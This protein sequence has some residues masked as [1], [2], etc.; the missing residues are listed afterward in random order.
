MCITNEM[1]LSVLV[2]ATLDDRIGMLKKLTSNGSPEPSSPGKST[3]KVLSADGKTCETPLSFSKHQ[4]GTTSKIK[5]TSDTTCPSGG[6]CPPKS[7]AGKGLASLKGSTLKDTTG[8]W[9]TLRKPEGQTRY[10]SGTT[11]GTRSRL[12]LTLTPEGDFEPPESDPK[13]DKFKADL[14]DQLVNETP[15]ETMYRLKPENWP[16]TDWRRYL[17]IPMTMSWCPATDPRECLDKHERHERIVMSMLLGVETTFEYFRVVAAEQKKW[18]IKTMMAEAAAKRA[19]NAEINRMIRKQAGPCKNRIGDV[20]HEEWSHITMAFLT[21]IIDMIICL[22]QILSRAWKGVIQ[23]HLAAAVVYVTPKHPHVWIDNKI[24]GMRTKMRGVPLSLSNYDAIWMLLQISHKHIV[25]GFWP[26]FAEI[27][28]L[29]Q[30]YAARLTTQVY[31]V[32]ML[33][34]KYQYGT[35]AAVMLLKHCYYVVIHACFP[36]MR[37]FKP[38]RQHYDEYVDED[39][40]RGWHHTRVKVATQLYLR[41]ILGLV[42]W[43]AIGREKSLEWLARCLLKASNTCREA[44][45]A[46]RRESVDRSIQVPQTPRHSTIGGQLTPSGQHEITPGGTRRLLPDSI[47][48]NL[49]QSRKALSKCANAKIDFDTRLLIL[50]GLQMETTFNIKRLE[51]SRW[52]D[53]PEVQSETQKQLD[54]RRDINAAIIK[55]QAQVARVKQ[56]DERQKAEYERHRTECDNDYESVERYILPHVRGQTHYKDLSPRA[57]WQRVTDDFKGLGFQH[58]ERSP[59]PTPPLGDGNSGDDSD[60]GPSGGGEGKKGRRRRPRDAPARRPPSNN[61]KDDDDEPDGGPGGGGESSRSHRGQGGESGRRQEPTESTQGGQSGSGNKET[62]PPAQGEQRETDATSAQNAQNPTAEEPPIVRFADNVDVAQ[63]PA[64][65]RSTQIYNVLTGL[66]SAATSPLT[67]AYGYMRTPTRTSTRP[68]NDQSDSQPSLV[69]RLFNYGGLRASNASPVPPNTPITPTVPHDENVTQNFQNDDSEGPI[70]PVPQPST[71]DEWRPMPGAFDQPVSNESRTNIPREPRPVEAAPAPGIETTTQEPN[72]VQPTIEASQPTHDT[73]PIA[74]GET[75]QDPDDGSPEGLAPER[76]YEQEPVQQALIPTYVD[77]IAELPVMTPEPVSTTA[78]VT[79]LPDASGLE[80]MITSVAEIVDNVDPLPAAHQTE[81]FGNEAVLDNLENAQIPIADV[82]T[83]L[84][85]EFPPTVHTAEATLPLEPPADPMLVDQPSSGSGSSDTMDVDEEQ[86][87]PN[88]DENRM[89][90]D[91]PSPPEPEDMDIT[92]EGHD[93]DAMDVE[94][95]TIGSS[96]TDNNFVL[97]PPMQPQTAVQGPTQSGRV[98]AQNW[99]TTTATSPS[100]GPSQS[101]PTI[102]SNRPIAMPG[103]RLRP[104]PAMVPPTIS[105]AQGESSRSG[106]VVQGPN[107]QSGRPAPSSVN[108]GKMPELAPGLFS[109]TAPN[110]PSTSRQ[111]T[112]G[113]QPNPQLG[114]ATGTTAQP[115]STSPSL[116]SVRQRASAWGQNIPITE[117]GRPLASVGRARSQRT[118]PQNATITNIPAASTAGQSSSTA[119]TAG[120]SSAG[121]SS[122]GAPSAGSFAS[123]TAP[124][125]VSLKL[126]GGPSNPAKPAPNEPRT[127]TTPSSSSVAGPSGTSPFSASANRAQGSSVPRPSQRTP[128]FDIPPM[129][130]SGI[131]RWPVSGGQENQNARPRRSSIGDPVNLTSQWARMSL[132]RLNE[133][134]R[135]SG[136]HAGGTASAGPTLHNTP[137]SSGTTAGQQALPTRSEDRGTTIVPPDPLAQK[138]RERHGVATGNESSEILGPLR[139]RKNYFKSDEKQKIEAHEKAQADE[140]ARDEE[141]RRNLPA[142]EWDFANNPITRPLLD[143]FNSARA[144]RVSPASSVP[145]PPTVDE[146]VDMGGDDQGTGSSG[147][148]RRQRRPRDSTGSSADDSHREQQSGSGRDAGRQWA[149]Y[150]RRNRRGSR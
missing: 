136:P 63:I 73:S 56:V 54:L 27:F 150:D 41:G 13:F 42:E 2:A 45:G 37:L 46:P 16:A 87:D 90:V 144:D 102:Q 71:A 89:E 14:L 134:R 49:Q 17:A 119:S 114:T 62:R 112:L 83:T 48:K 97:P 31:M 128:S 9:I 15:E 94:E 143:N 8:K 68:A 115:G 142:P 101:T 30:F 70:L 82:Q 105:N 64:T 74:V 24:W 126:G 76:T 99:Q 10:G 96:T 132:P 51:E 34:F 107:P 92:E 39:G 108:K 65:P 32:F 33:L 75:F 138:W 104:S 123:G 18:F 55:V 58:E 38:Y 77:E 98:P 133:S 1:I 118:A 148:S 85:T 7:H 116:G 125:S 67:S 79:E 12:P 78:P 53:H 103:R 111:T 95:N 5:T 22:F 11:I 137:S 146:E 69:N 52:P 40:N 61:R 117:Q 72:R 131:S 60:Q 43:R 29:E 36:I 88:S 21:Y 28:P 130:G 145:V 110:T 35:K 109:P 3:C 121:G 80:Y 4:S 57:S 139:M 93:D 100:S 140:R 120:Q 149:P 147:G 20:I 129:P 59:P 86:S 91:A 81:S 84:V 26:P 141:A 19:S 47:T 66:A 44:R 25:K 124:G 127:P 113:Q 50:K 106:S 23:P 135:P 6:A 122:R